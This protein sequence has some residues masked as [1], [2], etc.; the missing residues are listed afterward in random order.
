MA[1]TASAAKR[2]RQSLK[3]RHRNKHYRSTVKSATRK[4]R[5]ALATKDAGKIAAAFREAQATIDRAKSKG[6]LHARNA[7][8]RIGRLAVAVAK[9]TPGAAAR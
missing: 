5:E 7:A 8:R 1:N 6:V 9:A 4:L 3:R 2:N